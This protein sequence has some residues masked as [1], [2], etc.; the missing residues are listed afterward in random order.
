MTTD[1]GSWLAFPLFILSI[2]SIYVN[3][4]HARLGHQTPRR[5]RPYLFGEGT[6]MGRMSRMES[7]QS[8]HSRLLVPQTMGTPHEAGRS[9][10]EAG[11]SKVRCARLRLQG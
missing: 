4:T 2:L 9:K 7:S 11:A 3:S 8:P 5:P 10:N 1:E 6:W